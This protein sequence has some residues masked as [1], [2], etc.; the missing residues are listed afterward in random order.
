MQTVRILKDIEILKSYLVLVWSEW[1]SLGSGFFMMCDSIREDFGGVELYLHRADLTQRLDHVLGQLDRGLEYLQ[2]HEPE[3]DEDE[4]QR[5]KGQYG[6]LR[7]I[8]LEV[9]RSAF[10]RTSSGLIVRI[11]PLTPVYAHRIP[12]DVHVCAPHPVSVVG[13]P[14]HS[15]LVP[16]L[17][18]P[19]VGLA[20]AVIFLS[21]CPFYV[22]RFPCEFY[23]R[24]LDN[25]ANFYLMYYYH[26]RINIKELHLPLNLPLGVVLIP[27]DAL[28]CTA[29]IEPMSDESSRFGN[30]D[31]HEDDRIVKD[32]TD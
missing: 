15:V 2:Q 5:R 21:N 20:P 12:L 4:V 28:Q 31:L 19:Y 3:L 10:T 18:P 16:P 6:E 26:I 14:G 29:S 11:S 32:V 25:V 30:P 13:C 7:A 17:H 27:A 24:D 1:D 9:D 22:E 23:F 8:L